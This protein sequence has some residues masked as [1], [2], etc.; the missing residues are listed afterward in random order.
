MTAVRRETV[1]ADGRRVWLRPV[2]RDDGPALAEAFRRLSHDS[3]RWRFGA[4]PRVLTAAALRQ[5]IDA[6]DGIDHVAFAAVVHADHKSVNG[7]RRAARHEGGSYRIVGIGRILRYPDDGDSLDVAITVAD[8]YQGVGLGKTL[9]ELLAAHRPSPARRIRTQVQPGNDRAL[10]LLGLFG[11]TQRTSG[12]G[13]VVIEFE[14]RP[15]SQ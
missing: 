4:A 12:D 6:V 14:E 7:S 2:Q 9:A 3:A 8:D 10:A 13:E 15:G 1:L 5:L 11:A